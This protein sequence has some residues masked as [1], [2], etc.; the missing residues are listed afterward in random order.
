MSDKNSKWVFIDDSKV[1]TGFDYSIDLLC[2]YNIT[3]NISFDSDLDNNFIITCLVN[4]KKFTK[5]IKGV[6]S[7]DIYEKFCY[8]VDEVLRCI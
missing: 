5:K 8:Y 6:S 3:F 4:S 7:R 2:H 1:K